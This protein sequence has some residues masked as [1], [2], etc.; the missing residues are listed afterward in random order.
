MSILQLKQRIIL[1]IQRKR[2]LRIL[3]ALTGKSIRLSRSV[4]SQQR[5]AIQRSR[6]LHRQLNV[7][8]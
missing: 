8:I 7:S 2:V 1:R 3:L 4:E 6:G 5:M